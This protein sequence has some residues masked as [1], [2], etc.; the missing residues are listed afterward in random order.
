MAA[1]GSR[2]GG[3]DLACTRRLRSMLPL[4]LGISILLTSGSCSE[5]EPPPTVPVP[6]AGANL[7]GVLSLSGPPEVVR[8][9]A[10]S[11]EEDNDYNLAV[12]PD[13]RFQARLKAGSYYL[14]LDFPGGSGLS[15]VAGAKETAFRY[16]DDLN[17]IVIKEGTTTSV[18]VQLSSLSVRLIFDGAFTLSDV[19]AYV[20]TGAFAR[21]QVKDGVARFDFPYVPAGEQ[22]LT[23]L[24]ENQNRIYY[25]GTGS[26]D[27]STPVFLPADDHLVVTLDMT[28]PAYI[29]GLYPG[30]F[31][32]KQVVIIDESGNV[33][34]HADVPTGGGF[35]APIYYT[36]TCTVRLV[37]SS[38]TLDWTQEDG[39]P[40]TFDI[41]EGRTTT[42]EFPDWSLALEIDEEVSNYVDL[43]CHNV[44][45][46][47]AF[48][49][50]LRTRGFNRVGLIPPGSYKFQ[51]IPPSPCGYWAPTW[52]PSSLSEQNSEVV[53]IT[54]DPSTRSLEF[55]IRPGGQLSGFVRRTG[56]VGRAVRIAQLYKS[57]ESQAL[58]STGVESDG[59]FLFEGLEDGEYELGYVTDYGS[60]VTWWH[61]GEEDRTHGTPIVLE[62]GEVRNNL[63]AWLEF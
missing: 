58:C 6:L 34:G 46:G 56:T 38:G 28:D 55:L 47:N 40:I 15:I 61:P 33:V 4:V 31:V 18:H 3:P 8:L 44:T 57:G 43:L 42:L 37:D 62:A 9:R 39:E 23:F 27:E 32:G 36:G 10:V 1:R 53:E 21:E 20:G 35:R 48:T 2:R 51:L 22:P 16:S 52:H 19:H 12:A 59:H 14:D 49:R 45:T 41:E 60:I 63:E 25:P 50:S 11:L 17:P 54:N 26:P 24:M 30:P 13:G 7:S 5:D 29:E